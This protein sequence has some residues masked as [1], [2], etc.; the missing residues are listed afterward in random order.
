MDD[1]SDAA[2]GEGA[3]TNGEAGNEGGERGYADELMTCRLLVESCTRGEHVAARASP[4]R[5]E[6]KSGGAGEC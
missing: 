3:D 4:C 2:L 1:V 6:G 5:G